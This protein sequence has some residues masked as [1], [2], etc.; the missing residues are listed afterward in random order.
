MIIE[1]YQK[2]S[3]ML[4][5]FIK[6]EVFKGVRE[7]A[8]RTKPVQSALFYVLKGVLMPAVL[9]ETGFVTNPQDAK[10][11]TDKSYQAEMANSIA[12]GIVRYVRL[13][14]KTKGFTE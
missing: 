5:G 13:F 2:E 10:L 9:V 14:E 12:A 1:Q 3:S 11:I 8:E 6:E 4:S 7:V